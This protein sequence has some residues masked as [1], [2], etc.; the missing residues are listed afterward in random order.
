VIQEI[1]I[2]N[3][4]SI[5]RATVRLRPF[6]ILIGANGSGKSNL[7]KLL[8]DLSAL[9]DGFG[10]EL[11]RHLG[12]PKGAQQVTLT[13]SQGKRFTFSQ[14]SYIKPP[15]L[16]AVR[17]FSI[18]PRR[19]GQSEQLEKEPEVFPDG[20]GA[21]Q[22]LDAL[23]T[24]DREDLFDT[25]E[26]KLHEFVP[27][28]EKLS[29]APGNNSKRLQVRERGI[30]TP[31]PV[32]ELSE[33]TRLVL[34]ILT[35]VHQERKPSLI[36]FEDIDRGLHPA[37][38][39]KVVDV[40]RAMVSAEDAPQIIAT[41]HNP[42]FVDQF[43]DDPDCVQLVEKTD[44]N[45]TF[46]PLSERLKQLDGMT[47]SLGGVWYSGLVGGSPKAVLKHLPKLAGKSTP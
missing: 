40:C 9:G 21:V 34:T 16:K 23:K 24:G 5:A 27:E 8:V 7:L 13:S 41:T 38:F 17:V 6:T 28:V 26:R 31:V 4:R 30:Q 3:Y 46:T 37:L 2:T 29:F 43:V 18:D 42:Y 45:T 11:V 14:Q 12:H 47:D 10:Q 22:V 36:C 19:I 39:G 32:S 44:A 35:I 15:E 25:I 20:M 1:D 33:G